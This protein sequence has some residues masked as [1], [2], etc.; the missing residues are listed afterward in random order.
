MVAATLGGHAALL[1]VNGSSVVFCSKRRSLSLAPSIRVRFPA[2]EWHF[3][4]TTNN[5]LIL[6]RS[7]ERASFVTSPSP[8]PPPSTPS[9]TTT[10]PTHITLTPLPLPT[11]NLGFHSSLQ[12]ISPLPL[13]T[14]TDS[15]RRYWGVGFVLILFQTISPSPIHHDALPPEPNHQTCIN[16]EEIGCNSFLIIFV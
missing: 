9:P 7:H 12:L 10:L 15:P 8:S 2:R 13:P 6:A 1:V 5:H 16:I 11:P 14:V 3:R 4:I